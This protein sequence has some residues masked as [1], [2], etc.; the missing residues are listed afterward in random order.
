MS[1]SSVYDESIAVLLDEHTIECDVTVG[2][3]GQNVEISVSMNN[4]HNWVTQKLSIQVISALTVTNLFPKIGY[5][6]AGAG[7]YSKNTIQ[8]YLSLLGLKVPAANQLKGAALIF[9]GERKTHGFSSE[10]WY[11]NKL[12]VPTVGASE[13]NYE[14]GDT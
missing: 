10:V 8:V 4:G 6:V 1:F 12:P 11:L 9:G 5:L 14:L 3:P 13:T 2:N 7:F